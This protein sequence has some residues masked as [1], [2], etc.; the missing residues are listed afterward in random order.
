MITGNQIRAARAL[1]GMSQDELAEETG[2]TPQAIR[3]IEAGSVTP[4]E[5]TLDDITNA[6][7]KK[8][9]E[10]TDNSGVRFIPEDVR[11]LN[12]NHGFEVFTD[13]IFSTMQIS[14]G[15]IRQ[16]GIPEAYFESCND[17]IAAKHRNRMGP[18]VQSRRDILVRTILSHGDTDFISTDYAEYRWHPLS[19]P[20]PVPYY[21]FG[22]Y[23]G[24]FA[25]GVK[26]A[27]KII[28]IS[29]PIISET[30]STQFD[31]SWDVAEI[32]SKK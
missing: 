32:P 13:L 23:I 1:I 11:V 3:K 26:P 22:N 19:A 30:F 28:L 10:F 25:L 17:A 6:F 24:I 2:L 7:Y 18:L 14:G 5:G 27:P 15:M 20:P 8:R 9:I 16:N 12:G 4:R 21:I 29:S 31:L